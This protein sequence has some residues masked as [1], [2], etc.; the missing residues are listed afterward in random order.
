MFLTGLSLSTQIYLIVIASIMLRANPKAS[1]IRVA[2]GGGKN[3][4]SNCILST[5][6]A[7]SQVSM[8]GSHVNTHYHGHARQAVLSPNAAHSTDWLLNSWLPLLYLPLKPDTP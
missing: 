6:T 2:M 4:Q 3:R 7:Q 8:I 1:L 5:P